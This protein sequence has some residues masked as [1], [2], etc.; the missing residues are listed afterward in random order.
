MTK[1]PKEKALS[2]KIA[3]RDKGQTLIQPARI[4]LLLK[5]L[6]GENFLLAQEWI[7]SSPRRHTPEHL[8]EDARQRL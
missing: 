5:S 8:S 4:R 3:P 1:L 7:L 2:R 6:L